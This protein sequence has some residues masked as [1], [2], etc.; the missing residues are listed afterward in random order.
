MPVAAQDRRLLR[1]AA[2]FA[3]ADE[4][5]EAVLGRLT[6][7]QALSRVKELLASKTVYDEVEQ[8]QLLLVQIAEQADWLKDHRDSFSQSPTVLSAL[9]RAYK[10]LSDQIERTNINVNEINT[11]LASRHAEYFM[12]GFLRGFDAMLATLAKREN[13]VV[14]DVEEV[15]ELMQIGTTA[16][17]A[18]VEK[19][20]AQD[21]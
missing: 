12:S 20:T 5:S 11:H 8:R 10:L 14:L 17:Q 9:N 21:D 7:A 3:T 6:P 4:L 13:E 18:Y 19:V 15:Q 16:A 1:A 2:R